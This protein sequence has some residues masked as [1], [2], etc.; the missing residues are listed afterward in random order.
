MTAPPPP[1][2]P[3]PPS[4]PLRPLHEARRQALLIELAAL[5]RALGYDAGNARARRER[6]RAWRNEDAGEYEAAS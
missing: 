5:N 6:E 1:I 4:D 2:P 3:I